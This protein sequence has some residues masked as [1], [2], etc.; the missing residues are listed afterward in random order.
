[1]SPRI[2]RLAEKLTRGLDGERACAA[3]LHDYVRDRIAFGFTPWLDAAT[4]QQTLEAGVGHTIPKTALFVALARAAGLRAFQHYVTIDHALLRG[5][6]PGGAHRLLPWEIPH[7]YA[8]VEIDDEWWRVDSYALDQS[9]WR[10]AVARLT[11]EGD[12]LGYGAHCLGTCRWR[13][14]GHAF[15]Q[16]VTADMVVED[17]GAFADAPAFLAAQ[18]RAARSGA[19]AWGD[20]FALA[21]TPLV[22]ASMRRVNEHLDALR[23]PGPLLAAAGH[24]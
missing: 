16:L 18:S 1:M 2:E 20:L 4:P 15:A 19:R 3:R 10:G 17:H 7:A 22:H 14:R 8:E 9:L 11:H 12:L 5:A 6:F 24:A 23:V 13:G 21:S